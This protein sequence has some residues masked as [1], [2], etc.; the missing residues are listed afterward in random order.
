MTLTLTN[1]LRNLLGPYHRPKGEE[2]CFQGGYAFPGAS[3]IGIGKNDVTWYE[4]RVP[5]TPYWTDS[6]LQIPFGVRGVKLRKP[7]Q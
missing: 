4:H 3:W 7:L 1:S 5:D 2:G 6:Y